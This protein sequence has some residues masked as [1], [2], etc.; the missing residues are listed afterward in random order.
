VPVRFV[1]E[2]IGA[3]VDWDRKNSRVTVKLNNKVVELVIGNKIMKVGDK[4][5]VLD[6]AP[7]ISEGRT[8]LPLRSLVEALGKKVFYDRGLLS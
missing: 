8:Y 7:E 4:E 1:S 2:S 6:V 5:E 3:Q